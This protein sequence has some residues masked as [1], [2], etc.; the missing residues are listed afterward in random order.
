MVGYLGNFNSGK[1]F[2]LG[3]IVDKKFQKEGLT[4]RTEDFNLF[5]EGNFIN[6]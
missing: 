3:K 4:T 6:D 5:Y 2:L 1:T